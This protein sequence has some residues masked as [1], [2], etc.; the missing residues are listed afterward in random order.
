M[1]GPGRLLPGVKQFT[2]KE[3]G[4]DTVFGGH[5]MSIHIP[6]DYQFIRKT[7]QHMHWCNTAIGK[8]GQITGACRLIQECR[9]EALFPVPLTHPASALEYMVLLRQHLAS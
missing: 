2:T 8:P 9:S 1:T 6:L 4:N 7:I 3:S 5:G